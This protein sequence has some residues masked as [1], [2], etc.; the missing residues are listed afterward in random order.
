ME[1]EKKG[2]GRPK[3]LPKTG[4][5]VAGVPNATNEIK[6]R[7]RIFLNGNLDEVVDAW[8]KIECPKQKVDAYLG[9]M[10]Y[11]YPKMRSIEVSDVR[12]KTSIEEKL[13]SLANLTS[14]TT[15]KKS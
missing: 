10:N 8:R 5:R 3:G 2:R 7:M 13:E 15:N 4:G 12:E 6:T 9:I 11:V 1:K 14:S